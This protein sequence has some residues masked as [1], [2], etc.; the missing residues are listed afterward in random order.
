MSR[1]GQKRSVRSWSTESKGG[2]SW[3]VLERRI[4]KAQEQVSRTKMQY[5][6][7]ISNLSELLDK[8]DALHR[9]ELMKA[10]MNSDKSYDEVM[11][12]LDGGEE[13]KTVPKVTETRKRAF[14][15]G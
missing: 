13:K 15:A 9:D 2:P 7:T 11:A 1:A 14:C 6:A 5:D 12:F 4:E 10:F 3:E 8:R